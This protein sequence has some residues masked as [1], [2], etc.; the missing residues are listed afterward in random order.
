MHSGFVHQ[1]SEFLNKYRNK[2]VWLDIKA[3]KIFAQRPK[4]ALFENNIVCFD[5]HFEYAVYQILRE[6][7]RPN[8]IEIHYPFQVKPNTLFSSKVTYFVDFVI[9]TR[10]GLLCVEAKGMI[11]PEAKLK[12]KM[13]EITSPHIRNNL[14]IVSE[15]PNHYFGKAYPSSLSIDEFQTYL[16]T[17]EK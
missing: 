8:S 14:I 10:S 7:Y 11:T 12:L 6:F 17:R 5:S 9:T 1:K 16:Q 4:D 3:N 15:K 2:K 13:L